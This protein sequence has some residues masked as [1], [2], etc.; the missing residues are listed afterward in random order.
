VAFAFGA[1]GTLYKGRLAGGLEVTRYPGEVKAVRVLAEDLRI[2]SFTVTNRGNV[3]ATTETANGVNDLWLIPATGTPVRLDTGLKGSSG[4]ALSPDG[5]WLFVAQRLSRSGISYSILP[6][7]ML[8]SRAPFYDF[9]V[10]ASA[11]DSGAMEV[12][13]DRDGRA[14]AAT[15]MGVQVFDRNGRVTAILPLPGNAPATSL[16]FG[17]Q[18]FDTLYVAGGGT[19]YKRKLRLR[20]MP[21]WAAPIKLPRGDAG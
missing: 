6:N 16:C 13:M 7:G 14:Y 9:Y 1:D 11:D 21:P 2:R 5:L 17:G 20:G 19:I 15:R 3:Y 10:P 4:V 12:A 18:D 8:A